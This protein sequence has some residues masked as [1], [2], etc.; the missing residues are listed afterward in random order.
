MFSSS[1][2]RSTPGR[3]SAAPVTTTGSVAAGAAALDVEGQRRCRA[4]ASI[5]CSTTST[6]RRPSSAYCSRGHRGPPARDRGGIDRGGDF[7]RGVRGCGESGA[8]PEPGGVQPAQRLVE[9]GDIAGFRVVGEQG[10]HIVAEDVLDE[11]VQRLLGADL[12]EDAGT[13]RVQRAQP[14]DEPDRRG[15]LAAEQVEH[16]VDVGVRRIELTGHVRHDRQTRRPHVEPAQCGLQRFAHRRHD[17]GVESVA[18]RDSVGV[19][20]GGAESRDGAVHGIGGTADD[21]LA[22]A[23][24]VRD[25]DV[26]V[27]L[28][29]DPVDLGQRGEHRRH[30]AVVGHR[31]ARHLPGPGR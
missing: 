31:Q 8:N 29:D 19:H 4:A 18:D 24:D 10:E 17:R 5:P 20:A 22:V 7:G 2:T 14:V 21:G 11:A 6:R 12:D 13:R 15:H 3:P 23:I 1:K 27:G 9:R 26:A 30:G 16:G 25:D 28:G